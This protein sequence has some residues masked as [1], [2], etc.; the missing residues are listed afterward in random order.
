MLRSFSQLASLAL[1]RGISIKILQWLGGARAPPPPPTNPT[2]TKKMTN[3]TANLPK[4]WKFD[5][6]G[7]PQAEI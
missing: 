2:D 6:C 1:A 4:G 7:P 3:V 5:H